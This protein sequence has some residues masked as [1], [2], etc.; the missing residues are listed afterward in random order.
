[1]AD[2]HQV[3]LSS[4]AQLGGNVGMAGATAA[5]TGVVGGDRRPHMNYR[6][7]R[8]SKIYCFFFFK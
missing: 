6:R 4:A 5:V 7:P 2:G 8:V 1:M 3:S